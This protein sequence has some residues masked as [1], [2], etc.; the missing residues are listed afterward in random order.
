MK[1]DDGMTYYGPQ[2]EAKY[3]DSWQVWYGNN[4]LAAIPK[5]RDAMTIAYRIVACLKTCDKFDNRELLLI[6]ELL[7]K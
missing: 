2:Y 7:D 5:S 6:R 4:L 1:T 3:N